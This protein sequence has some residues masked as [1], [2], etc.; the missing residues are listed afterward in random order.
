MKTLE[1]IMTV[2]A[3]SIAAFCSLTFI[4]LVVLCAGAKLTGL[5]A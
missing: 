3:V 2:A 4:A 5:I 1:N